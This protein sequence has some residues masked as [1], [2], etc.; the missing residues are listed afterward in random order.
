[1]LLSS[2][3]HQSMLRRGKTKERINQHCT[4]ATQE[5]HQTL[6]QLPLSHSWLPIH[7]PGMEITTSPD[8][9]KEGLSIN[10]IPFLDW[11]KNKSHV[12]NYL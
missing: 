9:G 7:W 12:R 5:L 11:S 4:A 2:R 1:M 3:K 10:S 6:W 8:E